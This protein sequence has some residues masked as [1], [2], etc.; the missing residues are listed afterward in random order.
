MHF[1][2]SYLRF[3]I[4]EPVDKQLLRIGIEAKS[5]RTRRIQFHESSKDPGHL[6][7]TY[8]IRPSIHV[9]PFHVRIRPNQELKS[10][11][12][13]IVTGAVVQGVGQIRSKPARL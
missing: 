3:K 8:S 6:L 5:K 12:Q 9:F 4:R 1:E 13:S 11:N 10:L 2:V 7:F